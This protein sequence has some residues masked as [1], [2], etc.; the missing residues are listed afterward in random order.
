[1][2]FV[3]EKHKHR[4]VE[5]LKSKGVDTS[6]N[7]TS[8]PNTGAHKHGDSRPSFSLYADDQRCKCFACG[9]DGDIYDMVGFFEGIPEFANQYKFLDDFFGNPSYSPPPQKPKPVYRDD[10]F[11][12][13]T[14]AMEVFE[15][16]LKKNPASEKMIRQFLKDRARYSTGGGTHLREEGD[17]ADYPEDA[18]PFLVQNMFYWPG[19]DIA[20]KDL[21][22]DVF[23][24]CGI[25]LWGRNKEPSEWEH[26]GV[27][28]KLGTGYK[29][30]YYDKKYCDK[31]KNN[32]NYR[33]AIAKGTEEAEAVKL[34]DCKKYQAKGFCYKCEKRNS[35]KGRAFPM[36]G[37]IDESLPVILV[38]GEMD[39][40]AAQGAGIKNLFSTGGTQGLTKPMAEEHLLNVPEII[41]MFDG[42]E[43]GRMWSGLDPLDGQNVPQKIRRAGY[44]G[45]I[46]IAELPQDDGCNDPDALVIAGKRD[47]LIR[48][49]EEAKEYIPP[50]IP[51]KSK[52]ASFEFFS[53]LSVKRLKCLLKKITRE[54]LD[55][56]DIQPFITACKKA[57]SSEETGTLLK[58]WGAAQ[59]EI[60]AKNETTPAFLLAVAG[61]YLSRYM[62]RVIEKE[63]TPA[64]ELLRRIKIQNTK[65]ELDF[66]ELD[67]NENARNFAL[68]G[69]TR[70]AALMLADIFDGRIIYNAAKNDKRFYFFNGHIWQHEPDIT[71]IIYNTL[72]AV[73]RHFIKSSRD[74]EADEEA[75]KKEKGRL[76]DVLGKIEGRTM[77]VEIQHEF[78]SLK[79]EGVYHNSDDADDTLRFDGEATKETLTL[80]DGVVDF[81]GK[82]LIF[83]KSKPD[84]FRSR[85]LPYKIG[86][87]KKG[88]SCE[89]IWQF[90]R[91]NFKNADTLDTLM[92]YI[93][94]IPSRAFYKYG[95][96]WI[97]GKNTGKSTT[98]RIIESIYDYLIVNLDPDII[99][100]KG[101]TFSQ[102]NGPT[103]YLARLPGKG[104]AF[105]SEPD[106]GVALNTGLWKKLT[107]GDSMSARGLN[108]ALKDFR[109]TAQIVINTN[110]LPKFDSHDDAVSVRAV[111]IPFLISHEANEEGTMRP[112]EFVEYL[113]PE[114]PAFIRL[115]AEYYLRF[116]NQYRGVIPVSRECE[117]AKVGYIAEVE[118]DLDRYINACVSFEP[119]S[120]SVIKNVYESYKTYYEF[121]DSSVK[122]GEAL[123]Q[124][125]FTRLVLKNYKDKLTEAVKRVEGKPARCFVGLR[126]KP[127][128]EVEHSPAQ[129]RAADDDFFSSGNNQAA[130]PEDEG[131]PF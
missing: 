55:K 83:R 31:C 52:F 4:L 37:K 56:D 117:A 17:F 15:T 50:E 65:I 49:I 82:E 97:G 70:S 60:A 109:N 103:P 63:L 105:I 81:S 26:S 48:A 104:A 130:S 121:D 1:M 123:T 116:K 95:G 64:D 23:M 33:E 124:H 53:D 107:G 8:C 113:R 12:P 11:K 27:V 128:D 110:H 80:Q 98:M 13:D 58:Q 36:P 22:N 88:G 30:H 43:K 5:Y 51:K 94:I 119:Q 2:A 6:Q 66:E 111:V 16:Y 85:V 42:D 25:P 74:S 96:F 67:I 19:L 3:R 99:M 24:K 54:K 102:G 122:R 72:L 46:R 76:M 32:E 120:I 44:V 62:Q 112:E 79:A 92:Y 108:E 69:G 20:K 93:S 14:K 101:K 125:R 89:K 61:K 29:L 84:E 77:R 10:D 87:V 41:L 115:M 129:G 91:G 21:A 100:P 106:D 18:V 73:L 71:G 40:L 118:T 45:K 7:P 126:I 57:F 114:F 90:F 39:A 59:K 35:R 28:L 78:A 34:L 131:A 47:V 75:K 68:Y 127:M 38:E 86:D 9:L